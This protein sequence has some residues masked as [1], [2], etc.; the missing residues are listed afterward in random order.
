DVYK[1]QIRDLTTKDVDQYNQ[2]LRYA[3]QVTEQELMEYGW[4]SEEIKQSKFPIIERAN[5]LGCYD[6]DKLISQF[7]VYPLKMN[8]LNQTYEIG[9][10]T[11]V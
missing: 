4:E 5:I 2:L 3:F 8:I 11:S 1:R 10:I 7:A 9:F 6:E